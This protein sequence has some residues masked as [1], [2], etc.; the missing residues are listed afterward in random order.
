MLKLRCAFL[1]TCNQL[2]GRLRLDFNH[3]P[4]HK[5][6]DFFPP[7]FREQFKNILTIPV[8]KYVVFHICHN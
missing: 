7:S 2:F 5:K 1:G 6:V 4:A 8:F 3:R